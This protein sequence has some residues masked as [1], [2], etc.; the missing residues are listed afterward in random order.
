VF[1]GGP[2]GGGEADNQAMMHFLQVRIEALREAVAPEAGVILIHHTRKSSKPQLAEDPFQALSGAGSLRSVYTAGIVLVRPDENLPQRQAYFELRN[3]PPI[4][5][6]ILLRRDN[7]WIESALNDQRL[8]MQGQG[9]RHDAERRRQHDV[10]LQLIYDEAASGRAY[11]PTQFAEQFENR[12]GLSGANTIHRRISV[13][14]TKGYIRFFKNAADYGLDLPRRSKFGFMCV[15]GMIL[16]GRSEASDPE[17]GEITTER[18]V[19]PTHYKYPQTGEN[20]PVEDPENWTY[21]DAAEGSV[22]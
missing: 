20:L 12:G 17:T 19:V 11:T 7:G 2:D 9:T 14:S 10:I 13:L 5:T 22:A 3:G 8:A 15:E 1:D 16:G 4:E 6:K 21:D 18:R